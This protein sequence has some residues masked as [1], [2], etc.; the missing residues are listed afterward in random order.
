M[1]E[2]LQNPAYRHVV[3]NHLPVTGL[4]VAWIVLLVGVLLRDRTVSRL[5]LVLVA[6][7][8]G[9]AIVVMPAGE[10]AY[11][12][13][14]DALDGPGRARLDHHADLAGVWGLGLY[15]TAVLALFG[16]GAS[17]WREPATRTVSAVVAV[18]GFA[19]LGAALVVAEAGGRIRHAESHLA[20]PA[21]A[22]DEAVAMRRLDPDQYRRALVD[23]FGDEIEVDGHLEPAARRSGLLAVGGSQVTITPAAFERYESSARA[24]ARQ[25]TAEDGRAALSCTPADP[26]EPDDACT[27]Q[28]VREAGAKLFRR[29]LTDPEVAARVQGAR[30]VAERDGDFY[31]GIRLALTSMMVSPEFLFRIER[32]EPDPSESGRLRLTG[33]TL[34]VR[35]SYLF[36]NAPPDDELRAAARRGDLADPDGLARQID[37]L[38][39]SPRLRDGV[40]AFF[41][42][43]LRFDE[44][45]EINKDLSRFPTYTKETADEAR[46]QTLRVVVDHLLDREADYRDL[47]TT[48]RSFMTRSLGALY[49]VPVRSVQG[50]EAFEFPEDH[51]RAG[52][53][54]HA[55]LN[56]L[57]A[58][59]A[60][61]SP[62][63]RGQFLREAILC[64]E[65][66]PA[67]ADV[68][69]ALFNDDENP[70]RKTARQRLEAH[71][72]DGSCRSCH[73]LTDPIGLGLEQFDAIGAPREV[74][75]GAVIDAS[76]DLDGDA[77]RGVAEMGQA[78]RNHP[79][80]VPCV[81]ETLYQ[82]AVGRETLAAERPALANLE[83]QFEASGFTF[84]ALLRAVAL[85][86]TF[87]GAPSGDVRSKEN[88]QTASSDATGGG[89]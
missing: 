88:L 89:A 50:W 87:R 74:E 44:I 35:L 32:I 12:I 20:A 11:P 10:D 62:T 42:D 6:V 78:F 18:A 40:R 55:S 38:L 75:N 68:E 64:Q 63:L 15:A 1:E 13:V 49:R 79:A 41:W 80:L 30:A 3:L 84:P 14:Y 4:F 56:M 36:W 57:H 31:A 28:I 9:S 71:S 43:V 27:E 76:G 7:M 61:S 86:E 45:E 58:H 54:T 59:P 22:G 29:E 25:V 53:L 17:F 8:A 81:V 48:R 85:T 46:E 60:R 5:G 69:F 66:P 37:R 2:L 83:R 77:F 65:V 23:A 39:A 16:L 19:S 72:S 67:P 47:F 24:V 21:R 82:Y 33:D 52:L 34:A 51:L 70:D 26:A 73:K